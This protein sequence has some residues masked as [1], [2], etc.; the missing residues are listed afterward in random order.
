MFGG[1]TCIG[2]EDIARKREGGL[3]IAPPVERGLMMKTTAQGRVV[4]FT[5]FRNFNFE[6]LR[7]SYFVQL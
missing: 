3:E 7:D 6:T 1:D 5:S 2:L 4:R